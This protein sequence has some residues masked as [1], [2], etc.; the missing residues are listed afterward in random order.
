MKTPIEIMII[1][2]RIAGKND[3]V[4]IQEY[5]INATIMVRI[6][7]MTVT[8]ILS[9]KFFNMTIPLSLAVQYF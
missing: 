7:V 3:I 2:I 4:S 6:K 8:K 5:E 1:R 9:L